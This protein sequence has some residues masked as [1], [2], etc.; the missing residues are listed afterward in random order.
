MLNKKHNISMPG[1][2]LYI[3]NEEIEYINIADIKFI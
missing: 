1:T 3:D 2:I